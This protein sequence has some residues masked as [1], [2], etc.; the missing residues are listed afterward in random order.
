MRKLGVSPIALV[1]QIGVDFALKTLQL[2][3]NTT[4]DVRFWDINGQQRRSAMTR[5]YYRDAVGAL[6][7]FDTERPETLDE[8]LLWKGDVDKHTQKRDGTLIPAV[9][10]ANKCDVA[11]SNSI[12][13]QPNALDRFCEQHGFCAWFACSAKESIRVDESTL[14][15]VNR[16]RVLCVLLLKDVVLAIVFVHIELFSLFQS[17]SVALP[18]S[19]NRSLWTCSLLFRFCKRSKVISKTTS[20]RKRAKK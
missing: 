18:Q 7:V 12:I 4:V 11:P 8:A 6:V 19:C 9:L 3:Q 2:D 13:N 10:L 5:A 17:Q 16:V 20:V 14:F 1:V 15:L